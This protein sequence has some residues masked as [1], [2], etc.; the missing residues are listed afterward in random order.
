M[1]RINEETSAVGGRWIWVRDKIQ[2][3]L[4]SELYN[5]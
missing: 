4:S 5:V 3:G 1:D 2:G